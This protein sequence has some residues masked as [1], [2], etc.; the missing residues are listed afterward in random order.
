MRCHG[1]LPGLVLFELVVPPLQPG[2]VGPY[3]VQ[4]VWFPSHL[5]LVR[6]YH[7]QIFGS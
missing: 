5:Q 2:V 3:P 4:G 7:N 6:T 1:L